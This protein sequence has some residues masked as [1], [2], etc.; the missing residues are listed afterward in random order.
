MFCAHP[1]PLTPLPREHEHHPARIT[2]QRS[3]TGHDAQPR[4][5]DRHCGKTRQQLF[6]TGPRDDGTRSFV[7]GSA[8]NGVRIAWDFRD[9]SWTGIDGLVQVNDPAAEPFRYLR[10]REPP[11]SDD[12]RRLAEQCL[13]HG[14]PFRFVMIVASPS[15]KRFLVLPNDP[16]ELWPFQAARGGEQF[17]MPDVKR[18]S[19]KWVAS[20]VSGPGAA[21]NMPAR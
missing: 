13:L 6:P 2:V 9:E 4:L 17:V 10:L 20:Y 7:E 14:R 21:T 1:R 11:Y 3:R 5:A 16:I 15:G 12:I 19:G 18:R 8:P